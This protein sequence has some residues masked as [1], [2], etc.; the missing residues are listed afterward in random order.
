VHHSRRTSGPQEHE[1]RD[2]LEPSAQSSWC[3]GRKLFL[4]TALPIASQAL[5]C[6]LIGSKMYPTVN[7]RVGDVVGNLLERR[8]LQHDVGFAWP[9]IYTFGILSGWRATRKLA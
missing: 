1:W 5:A 9:P 4:Y 2:A 6:D 8:V 3:M 7:A